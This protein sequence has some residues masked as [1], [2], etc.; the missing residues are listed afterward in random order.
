MEFI[1]CL[2]LLRGQSPSA[3]LSPVE[4]SKFVPALTR[5]YQNLYAKNHEKLQRQNPDFTTVPKPAEDSQT[6]AFSVPTLGAST[7]PLHPQRSEKES[8]PRGNR[9]RKKRGGGKKS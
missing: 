7:I 8:E 1:G 9:G 2:N 6:T 3:F 4:R 5:S